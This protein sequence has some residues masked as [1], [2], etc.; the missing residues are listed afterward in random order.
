MVAEGA[1]G[2]G[3][4]GDGKRNHGEETLGDGAELICVAHRC[5]GSRCGRGFPR[6]A[7]HA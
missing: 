6:G 4:G 2:L 5:E 3:D 7:R 1:K